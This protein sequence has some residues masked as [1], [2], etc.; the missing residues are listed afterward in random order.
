M[1]SFTL[2]LVVN[3][4]LFLVVL[5]YCVLRFISNN[6]VISRFSFVI[7]ALICIFYQAPLV[8]FSNQLI[9]ALENP[10][11]YAFYVNG[12]ACILVFYTRASRS[13]DLKIGRIPI[14]DNFLLL[15]LSSVL[16]AFLS[17]YTYLIGI[18]WQC[19]GLYALLYDP[20]LTLL[21]REFGVKLIG[22]SLNT[23]S[24]GAYANTIAPIVAL[25]S[26]WLMKASIAQRRFM[27][28]ISGLITGLLAVAGVLIS[29]TKGLLMP[30]LLMLLIGAYFWSGTWFARI[31]NVAL[32]LSFVAASLIGFELFKERRS[33]V[34]TNY[35]FAA[36]SVGA[37]TCTKSLDMLDS[38]KHRDF[39]LGLP[40]VFVKP[41]ENR[42]ICLCNNE[43]TVESCPK[44][45]LSGIRAGGIITDEAG[46]IFTDKLLIRSSTFAEA[47]FNRIF[48]VPFQVSVWY[49]M[50][51]ETETFN[52]WKTLPFS[53]RILGESLNMP[54]LVYQKYGVI[55]SQGDRTITSTAPT[56]FLLSYPA[57]LG[58]VGFVLA[59]VC[60]VMLDAVLAILTAHI[61]PSLVPLLIG[62]VLI[63]SINFMTSDFVT[64]LISHGGAVGILLVGISGFLLRKNK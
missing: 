20:W 10:W 14:P 21:A 3:F 57:S 28:V 31:I 64:V 34:G 8:L 18:P 46:G 15:Y 54:E 45:A 40:S 6:L 58:W 63:M 9:L 60:I 35:D 32:S 33:F 52:G 25:L 37:G 36:C 38:M 17:I 19:T 24:L 56:S 47:V 11:I 7:T 41:I 43:G 53:R 44:G 2:F 55:Y 59:L 42:L 51:T 1:P 22:S 49:F 29:G 26:I 30:M 27:W 13:I 12:A 50:Y 62:V 23:Y 16:I 5:I 4:I 61:K 48:V 39:S